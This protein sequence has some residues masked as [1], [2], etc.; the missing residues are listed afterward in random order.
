MRRLLSKLAA[1]AVLA[2]GAAGLTIAA[3]DKKPEFPGF[4]SVPGPVTGE[5]TK[6]EKNGFMLKVPK[7]V[8][9]TRG[10]PTQQWDELPMEFAE[11]GLL[12]WD[13]L[14][15][16][17]DENGKKKPYT[18]K[19]Q[20]ERKLPRGVPGYSADKDELQVGHILRVEMLRPKDIPAAKAIVQDYKVK[21]AFI[22]GLNP[23]PVK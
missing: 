15:P 20:Q 9:G 7:V 12:R 19:E 18:A 13:R 6:V 11:G 1:V 8:P 10:R 17:I 16:K 23:G 14:P 4:V 22:I 5:V 2:A 21:Y 3:D